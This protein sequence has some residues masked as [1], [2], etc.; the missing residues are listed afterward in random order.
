MLKD[1]YVI[2]SFISQSIF[3]RRV[4]STSTHFLSVNW[5][6]SCHG[7][8]DG[9]VTVH[10]IVVWCHSILAGRCVCCCRPVNWR[11]KAVYSYSVVCVRGTSA[12][13]NTILPK[14]THI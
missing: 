10:D 7:A 8:V 5:I 13:V 14:S 6:V 2:F 3:S 12:V 1:F 4:E 11:H 9:D